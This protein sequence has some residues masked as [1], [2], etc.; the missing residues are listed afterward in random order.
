MRPN[1]CNLDSGGA[2]GPVVPP[3]PRCSVC[4]A[5]LRRGSSG[6]GKAPLLGTAAALAL[7]AAVVA[8]SLGEPVNLFPT[9]SGG[10]AFPLATVT[11]GPS[12]V[13]PTPS[14]APALTPAPSASIDPAEQQIPTVAPLPTFGP[15]PTYPPV[16]T[17][18]PL[19]TFQL[20]VLPD[21]TSLPK[22]CIHPGLHNGVLDPCKWPQ[23]R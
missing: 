4:F 21:P 17:W 3:G 13:P 10:P 7:A 5:A 23:N 16:P 2:W 11:P 12:R 15:L 14:A 22:I 19:P 20:P 6:R 9:A 1:G 8:S 18:P